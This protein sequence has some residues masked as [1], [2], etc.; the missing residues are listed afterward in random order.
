MS[1]KR[2]RTLSKIFCFSIKGFQLLTRALTTTNGYNAC[3]SRTN[4]DVNL[5]HIKFLKSPLSLSTSFSLKIHKFV[6]SYCCVFKHSVVSEI[7]LKGIFMLIL[8]DIAVTS[9]PSFLLYKSM[10]KEHQS[11]KA[12]LCHQKHP[13]KCS[14][15]VF[16]LCSSLENWG[17]KHHG[18]AFKTSEIDVSAFQIKLI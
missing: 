9:V 8:L 13:R 4:E 2:R 16:S 1:E 10:G 15:A 6:Q 17:H 11:C 7:I 18:F 5:Q 3:K 14:S 12:A